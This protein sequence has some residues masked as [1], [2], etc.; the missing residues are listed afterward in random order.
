MIALQ[1]ST[2]PPGSPRGAS[3]L[4][5]PTCRSAYN[6]A[7]QASCPTCGVQ[8]GAPADPTADVVAA[9]E[10]LARAIARA[11]PVELARA[12]AELAVRD[13]SRALP[14]PDQISS[15]GPSI[16]RA[17]RAAL[18]PASAGTPHV[19]S[20]PAH[21][22][23]LTTVVLALVTRLPRLPASQ[24]RLPGVR[25]WASGAARALLARAS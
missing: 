4:H 3:Y 12:Q 10:Q 2:R 11:T 13:A 23:L 15:R 25:A 21:Q 5:C 24:P 22:A 20:G 7:A 6:V 16:L 1:P 8:P 9:A 18:A 19:V 14:A 17:I